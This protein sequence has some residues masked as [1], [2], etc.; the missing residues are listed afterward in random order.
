[1]SRM[2]YLKT[3]DNGEPSVWWSWQDLRR[4]D[5]RRAEGFCTYGRAWLKWAA[6]GVGVEWHL[7]T[8]RCAAGVTFSSHAD[9]AIMLALSIPFLFSLYLS[10]EKAKW[11]KRLPGVRYVSG[12]YNSGEREIRIAVHDNAIW[13][14]LWLNDGGMRSRNWRDG[15]F[16]VDNFFLGRS[17]H[18]KSEPTAY[19]VLIEMPEGYYPAKVELFTSTWKRTRWPWSKSVDRAKVEVDGGIPVPGK[20]ENSWDCDDDAIHAGTYPAIAVWEATAA[21]RESALRTRQRHGGEGWIPSDGWPMH[22][23]AK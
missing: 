21:I 20:G 8:R 19:D 14:S 3:A 13:W 10:L 23:K 1:M 5:G 12:D 18:T 17:V 15:C 16:H 6:N 7:F 22:C 9:D 2:H 11:V 4:N